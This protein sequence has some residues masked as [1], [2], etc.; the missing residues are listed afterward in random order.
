[1]AEI[2][3]RCRLDHTV[4]LESSLSRL[5]VLCLSHVYILVHIV[6][7]G[8]SSGGT[9]IFAIT[10]TFSLHILLIGLVRKH[11]RYAR[12]RRGLLPGIILV[13]R[14]LRDLLA[15]HKPDIF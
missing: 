12:K 6:A 11:V 7:H 15:L 3:I 8:A 2:L 9:A 5:L 10:T 4:G 14:G 13:L 1:M